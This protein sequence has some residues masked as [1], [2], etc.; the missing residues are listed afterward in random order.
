MNNQSYP[1][2]GREGCIEE[3]AGKALARIEILEDE[4]GK[5]DWIHK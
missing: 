1:R 3:M 5:K 4:I 2:K